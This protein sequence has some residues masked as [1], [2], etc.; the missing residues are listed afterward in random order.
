M[1][2]AGPERELREV[3]VDVRAG[4]ALG[5]A[6]RG[7]RR[8]RGRRRPEGD[9]R[10]RADGSRGARR[11][12]GLGDGSAL[13]ARSPLRLVRRARGVALAAVGE[14]TLELDAGQ[15]GDLARGLDGSF[16]RDADAPVAAVDL[17]ANAQAPPR[18]VKDVA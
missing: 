12:R 11:L 1:G 9:L 6:A 7:H 16:R 8:P 5:G 10:V 14:E 18:G 3:V 15:S 13:V 4:P 17:E 2:P